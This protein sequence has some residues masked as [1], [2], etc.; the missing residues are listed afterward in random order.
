MHRRLPILLLLASLPGAALAAQ[1]TTRA[2]VDSAGAEAND[3]S[4]FPAISADGRYVAFR[5]Y[6]SNL[7]PGDG[8]SQH[9]IFVHDRATGRTER[10]S[11]DSAG[12]EANGRSS[13]PAISGDGRY[14][15]FQSR[16]SNLVPGDANGAEDVFLHDR[17]TGTTERVSVSAAGAE[18]DRQS[19]HPVISAD[20]RHVAFQSDATNLVASDHNGFTDV[21]LLDRV[22][23]TLE[24]VSVDSSGHEAD[25]ASEL[26]SVSA[27]GRFVAFSSHA[28][29]LVAGDTNFASD[30]FV[31]DR[32]SAETTRVSLSSAGAEGDSLSLGPA[33]SADGRVVAFFSL[34][35]NLVAGD[36]NGHYDVFTHD[37]A[38]GATERVSQSSAG[39]EGDGPSDGPTISADGRFVAFASAAGNLIAGDGNGVED[40][41]VRDRLTGATSRCSLG[42]AGAEGDSGSLLPAISADGR[43]VTFAGDATNLVPLD[44]NGTWD[45]F[46]RDRGAGA[47][48]WL[49]TIVLC[50]PFHA[51]V[52]TVFELSWFGAPP[53]ASYGLYASFR[54]SG[55]AVAGHRFDLGLPAQRLAAGVIGASGAGSS[56]TPPVP[57]GAVGLW[58]YF[59]LVCQGVG[60]ALS[61]SI[62]Q[63]VDFH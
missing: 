40:V 63:R 60:G 15:A 52:A 42:A 18:A 37:R 45:V 14:V 57:P 29:N 8:N 23:G 39:L 7:V 55:T 30:V 38:T 50:A 25:S 41:F 59:E 16:A 43:V 12:L 22:A 1:A 26:P 13:H 21:F 2:S 11:V 46:V 20:G 47:G 33:I 28:E 44:Q 6:A 35:S 19:K 10:V 62:P 17:L 48:A 58:T 53:G 34:A 4:D 36:A 54:A 32:A 56:S 27:N 5:S 24:R 49:N 31:H 9:D 3:F 61:D 51:A